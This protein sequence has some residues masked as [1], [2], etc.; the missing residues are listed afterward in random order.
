MFRQFFR[1]AV[2]LILLV[3]FFSANLFA[4]S[5]AGLLFLLMDAS[6]VSFSMGSTHGLVA[7][8]DPMASIYN[9]AALGY[10]A[11]NNMV[12]YA[13]YPDKMDWLPTLIYGFEYNSNCIAVGLDLKKWTHL[14]LS[15]GLARHFIELGMG[16]QLIVNEKGEILG[17]FESRDKVEGTSIALA[18]ESKVRL[19]VGMTFKTIHSNLSPFAEAEVNAFDYG[20]LLDVPLIDM[21]A[22]DIENSA[23][24]KK[25]VIPFITPGVY[26][27]VTN[28]GDKFT[29]A[30]WAYAD[31]QPRNC[32]LGIN[33]KAGLK[34][35]LNGYHFNAFS[36]KWA[37][38]VE[39]ILVERDFNSSR[40]VAPFHDIHLIDHLIFGKS[41]DSIINKWGYE[42]GLSDFIYLRKGKYHDEDGRVKYKTKGM[43]IDYS[44]PLGLLLSYLYEEPN[45]LVKVISHLHFEEHWA[46]LESGKRSPLADTKY[47]SYIVRLS[48]IHF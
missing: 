33:I 14:P 34:A 30:D 3:F 4:V 9:P 26:Y 24:S 23:Q 37:R 43:G 42:I 46:E 32:T 18:F 17:T 13:Y 2:Y 25:S 1:F 19:S 48:Q 36:F 10:Y 7:D 31:P 35:N 28:I 38:E 20:V 5:E 29:Y 12:G 45:L 6:P 11:Q 22:N 39:D 21:L 16:E 40:Y 15:V 44:R 47:K 41:D 8:N 27:S